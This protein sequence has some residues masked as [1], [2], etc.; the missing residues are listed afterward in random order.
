MDLQAAL[1]VIGRRRETRLAYEKR[2]DYRLDLRGANLQRADL[3]GLR[4]GPVRLDRARME[5]ANLDGARM[6][7]ADLRWAQLKSADLA[8]WN[9]ARTNARSA[10]FTGAKNM[11]QEHVDAMFGDS[12]TIL[13]AGLA[14]TDLMNRPPLEHPW[15]PDPEYRAW[16]AAGAPL[17]PEAAGG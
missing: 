17:P 11:T 5:G 16:L 7:G 9:N 14:R 12:T 1:T 13:P 10:D 4:L 15:S 6:E 8:F 3:A 2:K